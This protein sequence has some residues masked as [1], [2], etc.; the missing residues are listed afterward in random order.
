MSNAPARLVTNGH[1]SVKECRH[2]TMMFNVHDRFIGRALD[3]YGE[4]CE[5]E[6]RAVAPI[7]EP[8]CTVIDIGANIGTHTIAFA[9]MVGA[10]GRVIAF[11]PQRIVHQILCGNVA[12]N[13]LTNVVVLNAAAGDVAGHVRIP[14]ID[15]TRDY[16]FGAIALCAPDAE[17]EEGDLVEV[18]T[19]DALQL[20]A[21]R[22]IKVDVEG[23]EPKVI[24]GARETI[25]RCEPA[26]FVENNTV[27]KSAAVLEAISDVGYKGYWHVSPYFSARNYFGHSENVFAQYQPEAN[28]L[29]VPKHVSIEGLE[30]VVG[31][32]DDWRRALQRMQHRKPQPRISP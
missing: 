1:M 25:A 24:E 19:V 6:I 26:L 20:Q 12:L 14:S 7:L 2:G 27:E 30:P 15:P 3:L 17:K 23:M 21:C 8:G 29:C 18:V 9:K 11:E 28:L 5:A 10:Q 31:K 4:W 13:A 16:N 22:L 32:K